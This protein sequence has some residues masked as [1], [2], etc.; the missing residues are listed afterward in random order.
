MDK[1]AQFGISKIGVSAVITLILVLA[2]IFSD[3]F[4]WIIVGIGLILIGLFIVSS[5]AIKS[6]KARIFTF[7]GLVAVGLILILSA[8]NI[9]ESISG[10]RYV[11]VPFFATV[12]C[13]R[14]ITSSFPTSIP[15]N[16]DWFYKGRPLPENADSY[17][18]QVETPDYGLVSVG[19]RL[20]YQ[21]CN[22]RSLCGN[23]KIVSLNRRGDIVNIGNVDADKFVW[24]QHETAGFIG[25]DDQSGATLKVT[26]QPFNLIRDDPLRGGRQEVA[27]SVGCTIPTGDVAW[28]KRILGHLGSSDIDTFSGDN[29]LKVG[30]KINYITG[31]IVAVSDGNTQS[32]GWCVYENGRANIYEIED[33]TYGSSYTR[34]KAVNFDNRIKIEECCDGEVYPNV[35]ICEDGEFIPIEEAECSRRSDC[36]TLEFFETSS[37][38]IG[39]YDCV[40]GSCEIVDEKDVEC[41]SDQQCKTN[42]RCSRNTFTCEIIS[43]QGGEGEVTQDTCNADA[44][45]INDEVCKGGVCLEPE[46][47]LTCSIFEKKVLKTDSKC[48]LGCWSAKIGTFGLVDLTEESEYEDCVTSNWVIITGILVLI[49]GLGA[50]A[51]YLTTGKKKG[52]KK[53]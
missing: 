31:S 23:E 25:W 5:D 6:D 4:R 11:E 16:G 21:I 10:D 18:L 26:Y 49:G 43:E 27:N 29:K 15:A 22:S 39:R 36:G 47:E 3:T 19:K 50:Y 44:D 40:S 30:E 32:G 9:L 46:E 28:S 20:V 8:G 35:Q 51:I 45:C 17:S 48:G 53:R 24:I 37:S 38:S 1:K 7:I 2:F 12:Q 34:V 41:T 42:E 52:R 33:I 13:Q 14:G